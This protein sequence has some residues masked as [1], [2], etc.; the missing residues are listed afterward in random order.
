M[1]RD[2]GTHK[3]EQLTT[4]K[5]IRLDLEGL[6]IYITRYVDFDSGWTIV[7]EAR[8]IEQTFT[9]PGPDVEIAAGVM[10]G[11]DGPYDQVVEEMAAMHMV[12]ASPVRGEP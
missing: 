10:L 4:H 9:I 6:V 3:R 12:P 2:Y 1:T 7:D 8:G 11:D 5:N